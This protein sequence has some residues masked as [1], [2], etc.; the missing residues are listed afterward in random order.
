ML[1]CT[2][3]MYMSTPISCICRS[4][5]ENADEPEG[6]EAAG[7]AAE[8]LAKLLM[9]HACTAQQGQGAPLVE[10]AAATQARTPKHMFGSFVSGRCKSGACLQC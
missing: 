7:I 5:A 4:T 1:K 3:Y 10:G 6:A 8:A 2:A 9:L